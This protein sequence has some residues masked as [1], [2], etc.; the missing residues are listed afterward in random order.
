MR[1]RSGDVCGRCSGSGHFSPSEADRA[2][3]IDVGVPTYRKR[4]ATLFDTALRSVRM[5]DRRLLGRL[6]EQMG[7]CDV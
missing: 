4:W 6:R 1:G 7:R 3:S 5:L 2:E